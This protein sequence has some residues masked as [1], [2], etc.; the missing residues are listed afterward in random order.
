MFSG[1]VVFPYSRITPSGIFCDETTRYTAQRSACQNQLK[2]ALRRECAIV[3][4]IAKIG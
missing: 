3:D 4:R 2:L 1:D